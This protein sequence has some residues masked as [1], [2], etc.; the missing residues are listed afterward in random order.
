MKIVVTG[1][2]GN[3]GAHIIRELLRQG[4]G[5]IICFDRMERSIH[6]DTVQYISGDRHDE[7]AY[8][9]TM[10]ELK[11]D[12]VFELTCFNAQ[13]ARV[14]IE[15]FRDVRHFITASTVCTYGKNFTHFPI[16]EEDWFQPC[17]EYGI[18]KHAADLVYLDAF[19]RQGFPVTIMKPCTSYSEMSGMLRSLTT[20]HTWIDRVKKGKPILICGDGDILHQYM[21]TEDTARGFVGV[22]G[23]QHCIGQIYNLTQTGF[24]TWAEYHR[25]AMEVLGQEVE[26][27]GLP[28]A[29][30]M[31][32]DPER[33]GLCYEIFGQHTYAANDKLRRDVPEWQPRIS[34]RDGMRRVF[35]AMEERGTI[36]NSD[37]ET[38][39]DEIIDAVKRGYGA[40]P[41]YRS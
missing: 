37:T 3:I 22:L 41:R 31:E 6:P 5:D 26:L 10:R 11:P 28:L 34:L 27:V 18:N 35:Q 21:H 36:P 19:R 39:E 29:Q 32:I 33:F 13:D 9:R 8:I 38:W 1:G 24:T 7:Q 4:Y 20:E 17:T 25:T 12:A 30:L 40:L 23:R 15:A 16:R 2:N 14:S